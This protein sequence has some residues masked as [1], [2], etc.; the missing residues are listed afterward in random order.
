LTARA[1]RRIQTIAWVTILLS[2]AAF[3]GLCAAV[4]AGGWWYWTHAEERLGAT[5]ELTGG[6]AV[7]V[8]SVTDSDWRQAGDQSHLKE[9]DSVRTSNQSG[10]LITLFDGSTVQLFANT[11]VNFEQLR[12][13][14][15]IARSKTVLVLQRS[16]S[17]RIG[18]AP[19]GEFSRFSFQVE[20]PEPQ[21]LASLREAGGSYR[22]EVTNTASDSLARFE[23][24]RG[25]ALV[26]A[27]GKTV[28]LA[29][30][31]KSIVWKNEA[32]T[33]PSSTLREFV[34]NGDFSDGIKQWVE[35]KDQGGDGGTVDGEVAIVDDSLDDRPVKAAQLSREGNTTDHAEA[36]LHQNI[37]A[38]VIDFSNTLILTAR[39]KLLNQS[40]SGGGVLSSEYPLIIKVTYRDADGNDTQWFQGFYYQNR[41]NNPTRDGQQVQQAVWEEYQMDL[42][43]LR[44]QPYLIK[45]IDIYAAGHD[46]NS[47]VTDVSLV[48]D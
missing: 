20:T 24:R 15:Y 38:E 44:P 29:A 30:E 34:R 3:L 8:R 12:S 33:A 42:R 9:G 21:A 4:G 39:V 32:P 25:V 28:N 41:E 47:L 18:V 5:L 13:T 17:T 23:S 1:E 11:E 36:G 31:E 6:D 43:T 16:G 10:A 2:F 7:F 22:V 46:F 45:S 35:T 37:N 48:A 14:R 26:T 40:L 19:L 27:L